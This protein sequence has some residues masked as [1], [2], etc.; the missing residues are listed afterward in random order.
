MLRPV[1]ENPYKPNQKKVCFFKR[2]GFGEKIILEGREN[3]HFS[4]IPKDSQNFGYFY[5]ECCCA[6]YLA[7][8]E[9]FSSTTSVL[10]DIIVQNTLKEIKRR[11]RKRKVSSLYFPVEV[12]SSHNVRK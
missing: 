2:G 6:A 1:P 11:R 10:Q 8:G 3:D 4:K 5:D 7:E 12:N 9:E